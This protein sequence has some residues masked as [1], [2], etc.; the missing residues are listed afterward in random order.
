MY[1]EIQI[2]ILCRLSDSAADNTVSALLPA[3]ALLSEDK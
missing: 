2:V 3:S 1:W